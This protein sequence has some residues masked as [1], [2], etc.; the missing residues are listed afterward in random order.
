MTGE[1]AALGSAACWALSSII[2][3]DLTHR[4]SAFYIMAVRTAFGALF[5]L[6]MVLLLRNGHLILEIPLTP[7]VILV[8][9]GIVAIIGDVA[10]IQAMALD[11][12]SRVMPTASSLYI[13]TSVA[14]SAIFWG[15]HVTWLTAVGAAMVMGGIYAVMGTRRPEAHQRPAPMPGGPSRQALGLAVVA[16]LLWTAS[17]MGVTNAMPSAT[18]M[19]A[20]ALRMPFAAAVLLAMIGLRDE[21]RR[22]GNP[23]Q[24]L[25][26]LVVSGALVAASTLLFLLSAKLSPPASVAILTSTSPVF[27]VPLAYLF[28][29]ERVTPRVLQGTT[30]CVIGVWLTVV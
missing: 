21:P 10:F 16:G 23:R 11:S 13:I 12:V 9:S 26:L 15:Q 18:P 6:L 8:A 20:T 28:L 7:A 14:A 30:M 24:D 2:A 22:L 1:L 19:A 5:V 3:K 25:R 27:A 29:K 17:L 4:L